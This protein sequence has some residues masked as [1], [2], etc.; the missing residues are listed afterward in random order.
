MN[1]PYPLFVATPRVSDQVAYGLT[2]AIM[3]NYE[4]IKDSGPSMDGYQLD[5][6]LLSYVF[7]YHEAAVAYFK[8][9]GLWTEADQ[10]HNDELLRRQDVLADAWQDFAA[11]DVAEEDFAEAWMKARAAALTAA[12]LPVIFN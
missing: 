2:A 10:H 9:K 11:K 12:K 4:D 6:Q 7:P 3:E 1:Y 8:E 5:R